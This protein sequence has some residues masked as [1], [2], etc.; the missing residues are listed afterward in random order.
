MRMLYRSRESGNSADI[1]LG[2]NMGPRF[3]GDDE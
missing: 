3:L 1:E 2:S